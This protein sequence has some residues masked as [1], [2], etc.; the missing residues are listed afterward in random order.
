MASKDEYKQD[1]AVES[2]MQAKNGGGGTVT[3]E[4][5]AA[6]DPDANE[7]AAMR[8]SKQLST[9]KALWSWLLLCY[10]VRGLPMIPFQA[11]CLPPLAMAARR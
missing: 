5:D 10:S 4:S 9:K 1:F 11:F 3:S 6:D 7:S 2:T 8:T